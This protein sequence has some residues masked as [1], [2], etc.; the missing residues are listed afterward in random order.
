[1]TKKD[2]YVYGHYNNENQLRYIG[3]G[4][5]GR[6]FSFSLGQRRKAWSEEFNDENPPKVSFFA[7][8][9]SEEDALSLEEDLI[10]REIEKGNN[11]INVIRSKGNNFADWS[12][13]DHKRLA[14]LRSGDKHWAYGK[15]RSDETKRKISE[16][17]QANPE[18]SIA[19][20]WLGKNRD[21][22]LIKK[23]VDAAHTP[24]SREKR[25]LAHIGKFHTEEH[26]KKISESLRN[27]QRT[28]EWNENISK[29]KKGKPSERKGIPLSESH[30][31]AI[32]EATKG[33]R[34][35]TPEEQAKRLATWKKR[36]MTSSKAKAVLCV[37]TGLKYRSAKEAAEGTGSDA[38]H[39]QACCVG[40]R[41]THNKLRWEY[42]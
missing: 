35:L 1:M 39:I 41:K 37:D 2:F 11:L 5:A 22:D 20:P 8:F 31:K 4:R 16:T 13:E 36:G 30:K 23:L 19:R 6:A 24:E 10:N 25:R 12:K 18:K 32:S 7:Q 21:P 14:A 33:R 17:K 3:K 26:K 28:P 38:K 42:I 9:I 34:A 29:A 27:V 15:Q 40:R